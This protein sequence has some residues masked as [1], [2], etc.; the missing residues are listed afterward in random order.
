MTKRNITKL[1]I[2]IAIIAVLIGAGVG[3]YFYY[4]NHGKIVGHIQNGEYYH[5]TEIRPTERFKGAQ[6]DNTSYFRIK[7]DGKTGELYLVGLE[8]TAAPI[9]FIVTNYKEGTK[10]TVIEFEYLLDNGEDTTI[11]HLTAISNN[12]E[13]RINAIES[14]RV[15]IIHQNHNDQDATAL[16]YEVTILVF[17][18]NSGVTA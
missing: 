6:M 15:E 11:Q 14:H 17:K 12:D 5:L 2:C 10:Q 9:P 16:E 1:I 4:N 18:L 13:I 8:A 3:V 7:N